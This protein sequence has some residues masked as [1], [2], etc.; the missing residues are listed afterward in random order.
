MK[1][2][3]WTKQE[4]KF[5]KENYPLRGKQY[6]CTQLNR[7]EGSVRWMTSML[8][9]RYIKDKT[10]NPYWLNI[11]TQRAKK[12]V[13]RKRPQHAIAIKQM[14]K[15][16][17]YPPKTKAQR[18]AISKRAR[19]YLLTYGHPRGYL[20]H[21]PSLATRQ[22]ISQ[23]SKESWARKT[24]EQKEACNQKRRETRMKNKSHRKTLKNTN[25]YS[26]T[27][28]GKRKDL[29]DQFFRS[30]TEANY[31]RYLNLRE[32]KWKY[33]KKTFIFHKI[34]RGTMSYTPDFYLPDEDTYIEVKGWLDPK[35]ITKFKRMKKYY[36]EE[37]KK[38]VI[39]KEELTI[40]DMRILTEI[41]FHIRQIQNFNK[42]VEIA[43]AF[44]PEWE[45]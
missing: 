10:K 17:R 16:G 11:V 12:L 24:P 28:S 23:K 5:L 6:C 34:K 37:F 35:S 40:K 41:G 32:C 31:A 9:I 42:T 4:I 19:E 3:H 29:N 1:L 30:R 44:I 25:I 18:E 20:G 36:P 8:K 26:R 13:G 27:K 39:V 22:I 38:L 21:H 14:W 33:E 7:G 15:D 45:G 2:K 43:R